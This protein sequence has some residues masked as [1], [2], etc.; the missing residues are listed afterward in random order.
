MTGFEGLDGTSEAVQGFSSMELIHDISAR[1][2]KLAG[3][4]VPD[5]YSARCVAECSG[6]R[7]AHEADERMRG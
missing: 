5:P 1:V 7:V 4:T 2:L 6:Q 3:K